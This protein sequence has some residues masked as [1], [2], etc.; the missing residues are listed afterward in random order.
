MS[1]TGVTNG[2]GDFD[3]YDAIIDAGIA[4]FLAFFTALAGMSVINVFDDPRSCL[5]AA[6]ISGAVQ[7]FLW[8][9][10]KRGIV[11]ND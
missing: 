11:K 6:G 7:F 4:A 8:L 1:R 10:L 3:W 5:F 2:E 9:A